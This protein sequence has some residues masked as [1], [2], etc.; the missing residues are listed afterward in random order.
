MCNQRTIKQSHLLF[1]GCLKCFVP[2]R[3]ILR[4]YR[5][6]F[7]PPPLKSFKKNLD[8][9]RD[10]VQF[11]CRTKS[12][13]SE[14]QC[15]PFRPPPCAPFDDDREPTPE[16]LLG[17]GPLQ[18]LGSGT[19]RLVIDVECKGLQP[20]IGTKAHCAQPAFK[21]FGQR[22]LTCAGQ[23][24]DNDQPC[25]TVATF[26]KGR[27]SIRPYP[28]RSQSVQISRFKPSC[29]VVLTSFILTGFI[30]LAGLTEGPF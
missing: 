9:S 15:I 16:K 21:R 3:Q 4:P 20:L 30:S 8:R 27:L 12:T 26:H 19:A 5:R 22:G 13:R 29:H 11:N 23:S 7:H 14:P 28:D 17:K 1:C 24:T 10:V 2:S 18:R 6:I 25:A